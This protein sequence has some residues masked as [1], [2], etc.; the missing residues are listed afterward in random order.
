AIGDALLAQ[1]LVEERAIADGMREDARRELPV[2][3]P[4]EL[5]AEL[6][7][8]GTF[9]AGGDHQR[10]HAVP[11]RPLGG[12]DAAGGARVLAQAVIRDAVE[13]APAPL[14]GAQPPFT[15]EAEGGGAE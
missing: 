13:A 11:G 7:A 5:A 12:I 6:R 1:H 3:L 10:P 2:T 15:H 8:R 9:H 4:E 14:G